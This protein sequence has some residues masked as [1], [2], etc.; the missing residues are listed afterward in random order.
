MRCSPTKILLS[1]LIG[2]FSGLTVISA[3]PLPIQAMEFYLADGDEVAF[4]NTSNVPSD[5]M[6]PDGAPGWPTTANGFGPSERHAEFSTSGGFSN[7][8]IRR[9]FNPGD[10]APE[11]LWLDLKSAT[12]VS[13]VYLNGEQVLGESAPAPQSSGFYRFNLTAHLDKLLLSQEN[14]LAIRVTGGF[15]LPLLYA[16]SSPDY[17]MNLALVPTSSRLNEPGT[18]LI[19][20]VFRW[21]PSIEGQAVCVSRIGSSV[22]SRADIEVLQDG[23]PLPITN[24]TRPRFNVSFPEGADY[25]DCEIRAISDDHA[26][27]QELFGFG[28]VVNTT[29][30]LRVPVGRNGT[31]VTQTSPSGEG[32]LALALENANIIPAQQTIRFSDSE[33][34]PFTTAPVVLHPESDSTRLLKIDDDLTIEGPASPGR[35]TIECGGKDGVYVQSRPSLTL[36]NLVIKNARRAVSSGRQVGKLKVESCELIDNRTAVHVS[37][38]AGP[39]E[40]SRCFIAGSSDNA[41]ANYSR[42]M[43]VSVSNCLFAGNQGSGIIDAR[44]EVE[45]EFCTII[46]QEPDAISGRIRARNC[47]FSGNPDGF[48]LDEATSF[49]LGGNLFANGTTGFELHPESIAGTA[50]LPLDPGFGI[51]GNHGGFTRSIPILSSSPALDLGIEVDGSPTNDQ[52]GHGF[53]RHVG[54]RPDAGAYELQHSSDQ[55]PIGAVTNVSYDP[56]VGIYYQLLIVHNESPW[57]L[58]GFRLRIGNLSPEVS[59]YNGSGNEHLDVAGDIIPGDY[60]MV[61]LQYH[62][63]NPYLL[64]IPELTVETLPG[65][66]T[67]LPPMPPLASI[68]LEMGDVPILHFPTEA[69]R[70]Y[71][72]ECSDDLKTWNPAGPIIWSESRQTIWQDTSNMGES[73]L[74]ERY[75]RIREEP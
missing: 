33:G 53:P 25:A 35:V 44:S 38:I 55:L 39:C 60:R 34:I 72:I 26:E 61:V 31:T 24:D 7:L 43:T 12:G 3:D 40:I 17:G 56:F 11:S 68:E 52:R 71:Q 46:D 36:R 13:E 14:L 10:T 5:W 73:Q 64:I 23:N 57:A 18:P 6:M 51:P 42:R 59:L 58:S 15:A 54:P 41:L 28:T 37:S 19:L 22:S 65:A 48:D 32:S 30:V 50:E 9:S 70:N 4:A 45:L 66:T 8:H 27:T 67:P 16:Y 21:N 63:E 47:I 2:V 1:T 62:A 49:D 74:P 29:P 69:G 20:R 75:Y